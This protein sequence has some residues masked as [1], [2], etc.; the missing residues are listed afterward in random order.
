M[1]GRTRRGVPGAVA[2]NE[3]LKALIG[4]LRSRLRF[5]LSVLCSRR[6]PCRFWQAAGSVSGNA[7]QTVTFQYDNANRR[8]GL[9]LPNG[10]TVS[11]GYDNANE[12]TGVAYSQATGSVIGNLTYT[13]DA[14]GAHSSVGGSL[15][16]GFEQSNVVVSY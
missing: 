7:P 1:P 5:I 10:V 12:P 16:R 11:Y 3:A 2:S 15:A 9:T 8:I 4:P 6:G 13:Y 14:S